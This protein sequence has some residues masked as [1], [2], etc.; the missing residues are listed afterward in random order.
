M[1]LGALMMA[2]GLG[3][4]MGYTKY[5]EYR[6]SKI[7]PKIEVIR[8][9]RVKKEIGRDHFER[10]LEKRVKELYEKQGMKYEPIKNPYALSKEERIK[11]YNPSFR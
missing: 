7:R 1:I 11:F 3:S 9:I 2:A 8:D 4:I 10:E 5:Q 6:F